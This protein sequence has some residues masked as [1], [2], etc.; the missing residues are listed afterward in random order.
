VQIINQG[1]TVFV[2]RLEVLKQHQ[3]GKLGENASLETIF[4]ALVSPS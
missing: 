1:Q 3:Q 4:T 2:D